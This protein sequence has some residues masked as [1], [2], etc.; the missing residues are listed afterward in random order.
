MIYKRINVINFLIVKVLMKIKVF[1]HS[2]KKIIKLLTN[3]NKLIIDMSLEIQT[4]KFN[5]QCLKL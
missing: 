1:L 5:F 4:Y 2:K 3:N